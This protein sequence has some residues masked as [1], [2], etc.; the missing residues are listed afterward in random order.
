MA[1]D[2]EEVYGAL[3]KKATGAATYAEQART[4]A[5]TAAEIFED[6]KDVAETIPE[7]YTELSN[8]VSDLTKVYDFTDLASL[9]VGTDIFPGDRVKFRYSPQ[10]GQTVFMWSK[11]DG[12]FGIVNAKSGGSTEKDTI[13][14]E[15]TDEYKAIGPKPNSFTF[16]E[17]TST[18]PVDVTEIEQSLEKKMEYFKVTATGAEDNL[19]I[20]HDGVAMTY[21]QL[22]DIYLNDKYFL[23]A[24]HYD[25]TMIPSLP[26]LDY[27]PVLEFICTWMYQGETRISRLIING[28]NHAK[29]ETVVVPSKES[30]DTLTE[31]VSALKNTIDK[32]ITKE[33]SR[34]RLDVSAFV[35]GKALNKAGGEYA[36]ESNSVT[37]FC[38]VHDAE[39]LCLSYDINGVITA[40]SASLYFFKEDK[41]P[42]NTTDCRVNQTAGGY[43]EKPADAY[44]VRAWFAT[45]A[46]STRN[47]MITVGQ[48]T[49]SEFIPYGDT[50]SYQF[51]DDELDVDS[52]NAVQNKV[53]AEALTHISSGIDYSVFTLPYI[54]DKKVLTNTK[55]GYTAVK[56]DEKVDRIDCK[57]I[58]EK[59]TASGSLALIFTSNAKSINDIVFTPSL[60]LVITNTKITLDIYGNASNGVNAYQRI[61]QE[62]ITE[63]PLDGITEHTVMFYLTKNSSGQYTGKIDVSVD[64]VIYSGMVNLSAEPFISVIN[65][66]IDGMNLYSAWFEYFTTASDRWSVCMPMV[67]YF[68]A[69]K[70]ENSQWSDLM[71]D[72]FDRQDGQLTC[73]AYGHNYILINSTTGY[74]R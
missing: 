38:D 14:F 30:V 64:G 29:F 66:G 35:S 12:T 25:L 67:T 54:K 23:Y 62:N 57:Y 68:S 55:V 34:N 60:H 4:Y 17:V 27:D 33:N 28:E 74:K 48:D 6:I 22:R 1:L 24:E 56:C 59:G 51:I 32:L 16:F 11:N 31:D 39:F 49:P 45:S 40:P 58:W 37:D 15:V 18:R 7:D 20:R 61:L 3:F 70:Y 53:I 47:Y 8:R 5:T 69:H 65:D 19:T 52:E 13:I 42:Y 43:V 44:Y 73:D 10:N 36:S 46:L 50:F 71:R 9:K 26:P 2:A 41:T 63:Q 21:E 72:Y